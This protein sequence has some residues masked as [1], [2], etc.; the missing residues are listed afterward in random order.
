MVPCQRWFLLPADWALS[1]GCNQFI[2]GE[3]QYMLLRPHI[4]SI[5]AI[6]ATLLI[7]TLGNDRSGCRRRLTGI[8]WMGYALYMIFYYAILLGSPFGDMFTL[9][10]ILIYL[11]ASS[12]NPLITSSPFWF[13]PSPWPVTKTIHGLWAGIDMQSLP[14][15]LGTVQCPTT[16]KISPSLLSLGP[17]RMGQ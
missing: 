6:M 16:G 8:H 13:F 4:P 11:P 14:S 12:P 2:L 5:P 15:L 7:N 17:S 9:W 10:L 1:S 3:W